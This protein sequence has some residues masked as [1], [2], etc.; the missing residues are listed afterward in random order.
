MLGGLERLTDPTGREKG[1][2]LPIIV[3][4]YVLL[5]IPCPSHIAILF[6]YA[7]FLFPLLLV[8]GDPSNGI[9]KKMPVD[10]VPGR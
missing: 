9:G 8:L 1:S 6:R 10:L 4:T 2:S 3:Y 7:T 5:P